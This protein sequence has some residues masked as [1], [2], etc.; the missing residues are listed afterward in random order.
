MKKD[1]R[2]RQMR[3]QKKREKSR[4]RKQVKA[5]RGGR[6]R[7]VVDPESAWGKM[8][9]WMTEEVPEG[10]AVLDRRERRRQKRL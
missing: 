5:V 2:W 9:S 6:I 7:G 1:A 3:L 8:W 10:K 4:V